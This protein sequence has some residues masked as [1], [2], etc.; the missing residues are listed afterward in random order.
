MSAFK[1]LFLIALV[2]AEIAASP[3]MCKFHIDS[4]LNNA[5]KAV[6]FAEAGKSYSA[7]LYADMFQDDVISGRVECLG[8]KEG[9]LAI[10]K[11]N[12]LEQV[13]IGLGLIGPSLS[14]SSRSSTYNAGTKQ[15]GHAIT[16]GTNTHTISEEL[17]DRRRREN[18][19]KT[20]HR[21]D[22]SMVIENVEVIGI[23]SFEPFRGSRDRIL[24]D[25]ANGK[26]F[27]PADKMK[28]AKYY[29]MTEPLSQQLD[30]L[31]SLNKE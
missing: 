21:N 23:K 6:A 12:S 24:V 8:F 22:P 10:K 1:A 4:A 27:F 16:Y 13:I 5:R 7:K 30:T 19:M 26:F 20:R 11:L 15:N 25:A 31:F 18:E 9:A 2:T 28:T 3:Y 14:H 17:E 29:N